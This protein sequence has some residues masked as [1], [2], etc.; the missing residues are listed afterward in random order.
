MLNDINFAS[1]EEIIKNYG[2]YEG[3]DVIENNQIIRAYNISSLDLKEFYVY[4]LTY[5]QLNKLRVGS[6]TIYDVYN[7]FRGSCFF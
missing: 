4:P 7:K 5:K 3:Q 6:E 2:L 1:N